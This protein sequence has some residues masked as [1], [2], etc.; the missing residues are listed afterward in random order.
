MS[1][2]QSSSGGLRE[3]KW[4]IG[5]WWPH[6]CVFWRWSGTLSH[7][8]GSSGLWKWWLPWKTLTKIDDEGVWVQNTKHAYSAQQAA[9]KVLPEA[10][11]DYWLWATCRPEC[12]WLMLPIDRGNRGREKEPIFLSVPESLQRQRDLWGPLPGW[13]A[14]SLVQ[15]VVLR[16][17]RLWRLVHWASGEGSVWASP[18]GPAVP[19][20]QRDHSR[21]GSAGHSLSL[22]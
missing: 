22:T 15:G 14:G 7:C 17:L 4:L 2:Y 5:V 12:A 20:A 16:W 10:N 9:L 8:S 13:Q 11:N 21:E 1:K 19:P 18:Q 3:Y 6:T